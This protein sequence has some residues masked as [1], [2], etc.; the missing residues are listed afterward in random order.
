M[1][2]KM[3]KENLE[4]LSYTKI[5]EMYLK[6]NKKTMNT[7]DLFKEV[8]KLLELSDEEY[9]D[10]I[11]DF[12]ESLTTSKDFILLNDGNWDLKANHSVKIDMDDIYEESDSGDEEG[13]DF[14]DK[15]LSEEDNYEDD[16]YDTDISDDDLVDD[17]YADLTIVDDNELEEN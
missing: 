12:F 6:E 14:E 17:D 11:G 15:E 7:A 4:L 3:S 8:C 13:T 16:N 9:Q 10:K 5:A 2:S 1:L